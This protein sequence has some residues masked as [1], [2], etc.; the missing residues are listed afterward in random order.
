MKLTTVLAAAAA[1][2]LFAAGA[3]YA[4]T[5]QEKSPGAQGSSK[6]PAK[7]DVRSMRRLAQDNLAEIEAG[8]LAAEKAQDPQ[9]KEFG[10]KMV[11]DH[12]KLLDDLKKVAE[13]KNVELPT[14]PDARHEKLMKRLQAASGEKFDREYMQAMVKD[15]RSALRLVQRT[16]KSAKD[17][18]LK[19]S[20]QNAVP[21]IQDHLKMA[22][23]IEKSEKS[24]KSSASGKT[25]KASSGSEA[26]SS[27]S[28]AGET[29]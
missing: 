9:V 28:Q 15:H 1:S 19:S 20:A 24:Q 13:S 4:Q 16:A 3:G 26:G 5:D 25:G 21:E 14:A 7:G 8:K 11:D 2:A 23:Q 18:D 22:Q 12:T 27:D 6:A 10:Q 17:A 29:R